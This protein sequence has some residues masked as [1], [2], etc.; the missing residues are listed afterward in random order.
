MNYIVYILECRDQSLYTGITNNL[1]ERLATHSKGKGSKYVRSRLPF[2]CVYQEACP[3]KKTAL[4]R[5]WAIKK[6]K[7]EDKLA[8]ITTSL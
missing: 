6:M 3:D 1:E 4:Q 5:E 8:L 2:R 7:R